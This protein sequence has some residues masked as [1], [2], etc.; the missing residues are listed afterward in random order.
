M[1]VS[2]GAFGGGGLRIFGVLHSDKIY[3]VYFSMPGRSWILQYCVHDHTAQPD[4]T[5]RIVQFHM[6]AA[7]VPPAPIVQSDFH[8]P[9]SDNPGSVGYVLH[10][11]IHDDGSVGDLKVL[12]GGDPVSNAAAII[13]FSRWKF[14]PATRGGVPV[15]LEVLVGIP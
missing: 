5:T 12:E 4:P 8:R 9:M 1:V 11:I 13:A 15:E 3:S 6:Q 14:R 10:G 2:T 7:L